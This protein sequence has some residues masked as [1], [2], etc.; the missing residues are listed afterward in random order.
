MP[1]KDTPSDTYFHI[2]I[3]ADL[4]AVTRLGTCYL[5]A[6]MM[7]SPSSSLEYSYLID[8]FE[9]VQLQRIT[10][11]VNQESPII[12]NSLPIDY[13]RGVFIVE[14]IFAIYPE[15]ENKSNEYSH[16]DYELAIAFNE[17]LDKILEIRYKADTKHIQH[18][19]SLRYYARRVLYKSKFVKHAIKFHNLFNKKK[20]ESK[21]HFA[22]IQ[23]LSEEFHTILKDFLTNSD[24]SNNSFTLEKENLLD[25]KNCPKK[26][27]IFLGVFLGLQ[28]LMH[29]KIQ[30]K[31][32]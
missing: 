13:I 28:P 10:D 25:I 32:I 2:E 19:K 22:N 18:W 16:Q 4:L 8:E 3:A 31:I 29:K 9:N 7:E 20:K 1:I 14:L 26:P 12:Y 6:W 27:L 21:N 23:Q 30:K 24:P 15:T 5:Y 11:I 17:H